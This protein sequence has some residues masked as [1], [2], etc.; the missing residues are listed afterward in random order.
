MRAAC[1]D[2][3]PELFFPEDHIASAGTKEW[4][5]ECEAVI[6]RWCLRCPVRLDCFAKAVEEEG[7]VGRGIWGGSDFLAR[8]PWVDGSRPVRC[9]CGKIID[10]LPALRLGEVPTKCSDCWEVT[11]GPEA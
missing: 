9:S 6:R 8:K 5:E 2:A 10:P 1:Q 3:P 4:R 7:A 11:D